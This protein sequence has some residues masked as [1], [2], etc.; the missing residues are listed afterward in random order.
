V[1]QSP[2]DLVRRAG[3]D[4]VGL[5]RDRRFNISLPPWAVTGTPELHC[6]WQGVHD[7]MANKNEFLEKE[8][9]CQISRRLHNFFK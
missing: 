2:E 7:D 4:S 6:S 3:S 5:R 9:G 1:N 8:A